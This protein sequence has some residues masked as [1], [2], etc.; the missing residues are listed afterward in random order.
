MGVAI[1]VI[2]V[3]ALL[4]LAGGWMWMGR[5]KTHALQ[6]R[7]GP[8]YDRAL[9]DVG[10]RRQAE[11]ELN[12]RRKRV[13]NLEIVEVTPQER[14]SFS[15]EWTAVQA[16]FVDTPSEAIAEADNLVTRVMGRRGYPMADFDQRA[17]DISVDYP[18]VVSEYRDARAVAVANADGRASTED[19]RQAMLHYRALF[20][21]LLGQKAT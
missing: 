1:A 11:A 3:V 19:L 4:A 6:D 8:E 14:A 16:H 9:D 13:E 5:R 20:G 18:E 15:A 10:S 7:F 2:V 21:E 17:A 12:A